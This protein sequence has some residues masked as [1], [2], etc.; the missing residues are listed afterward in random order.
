LPRRVPSQSSAPMTRFGIGEWYGKSFVSMTPAE[1]RTLARFQMPP[2][3]GRPAPSCP[4]QSSTEH[5][6]AC[7]KAGGVCT[8]PLYEQPPST[9]RAGTV[10]GSSGNLRTVCP[11]RFEQ[12]GLI[13]RWVAET[14]LGSTTP[15]IVS[16]IGFLERVGDQGEETGGREDVGRIDKVL[17]VPGVSPLKWCA[18]E[19]QAVYFSG[20]SMAKEW[21]V[22]AGYTRRIGIPFPGGRRR[23]DYRS[24]GPK[25]LMPQLQIKVPSLRRWGKKMAVVIDEGFWQAMGRMEEVPDVSNCYVAWFVVEYK[26]EPDGIKLAPGDVHLTTLERSVEGLTAGVP[27]SLEVFEQRILAKLQA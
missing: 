24:S 25:R 2:A 6:V 26:E 22:I 21:P 19:V 8:L 9:H 15:R 1:R 16:Q 4:F 20:D 27:V 17:V 12:D 13:Y 11:N 23:P 14:I 18:V 10:L 7:N 3:R 5:A